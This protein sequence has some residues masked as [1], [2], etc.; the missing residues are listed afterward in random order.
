MVVY[1]TTNVLHRKEALILTAIDIIDELGIQKLTTRE[2]AKRQNISEATLF[3]HF[4]NK[5]ELLIGVLDYFI[6]FDADIFQTTKINNLGPMKAISY[7]INT[8]AGY[9][10]NY[11]AIASILLIF[12]VLQYEEDLAER[13]RQIQ[14]SRTFALRQLLDEAIIRGE[15]RG[16]T[17]SNILAVMISGFFREICL[18]WKMSKAAFSLKDQT[19]FALDMLLKAFYNCEKKEQNDEKNIS[20]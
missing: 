3:R 17:D 11:P 1:M 2:I 20:C 8:Y 9:Y 12:D 10:E 19:L 7:L 5:N 4:K 15:L 6:Q 13:I 18:N 16:D 14:E